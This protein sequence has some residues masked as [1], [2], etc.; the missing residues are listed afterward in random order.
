MNESFIKLATDRPIAQYSEEGCVLKHNFHR[1]AKLL[2]QKIARKMELPKGSYEIRTN[3]GGIAVCGETTLH[4]ENIYIQ[5]GQSHNQDYFMFRHCK[6]RKDY[7]GGANNWMK[8][9][10]LKNLDAACAV[11][12]KVATGVNQEENWDM[13]KAAP[14]WG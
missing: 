7:T 12:N 4:G 10:M 2:L 9:D 13:T 14:H 11:F 5:F 8:W 6:G 1:A 3:L